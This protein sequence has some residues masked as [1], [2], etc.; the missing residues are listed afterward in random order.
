MELKKSCGSK[1]KEYDER[2]TLRAEELV[3]ISETIKILNDDDALDLFK[4]TLPSPALLQLDHRDERRKEALDKLEKVKKEQGVQT[5]AML[6]LITM[7]LHGKKAGFEKVVQMVDKLLGQLAKEQ[8]DDDEHKKWCLQEFDTAEDQETGL[9]RRIEGLETKVT[10]T[11]EGITTVVADL[12]ELK[13]GLRELDRAVD[14]ATTQRK[15]EHKEFMT[16]AAENNAAL[17]LLEV[18]RNRLSKFYQPKLYV[19]PARREL[20]PEEKIYVN[21]GGEDP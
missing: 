17:Q 5:N 20:T 14:D 12:A 21:S 16:T 10:E 9:K 19:G 11:E 1:G 7:A 3:A 4:K 13:K 15:D 8:V 6:N 2:K 18:A